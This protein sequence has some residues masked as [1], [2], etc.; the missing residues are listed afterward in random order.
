MK[1]LKWFWLPAFAL[2]LTTPV[3]TS[4]GGDD[5]EETTQPGNDDDDNDDN[6]N[7]SNGEDNGNDNNGGS[8]GGNS[9]GSDVADNAMSV[10]RQKM[11]LEEIGVELINLIKTADFQSYVDLLEYVEDTYYD[12]ETDEVED[13]YEGCLENITTTL[14][15]EKENW[16]DW[17][18]HF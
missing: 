18:I 1:T 2:M 14:G 5:E 16:N 13:W 17:F 15:S 10:T 12:Y 8:G 7:D 9:D 11:H 6:G 3:I 4:C